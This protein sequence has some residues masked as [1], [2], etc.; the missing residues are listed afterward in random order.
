MGRLAEA[1]SGDMVLGIGVGN[2]IYCRK[3]WGGS[4]VRD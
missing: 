4:C 2:G 1:K 3:L